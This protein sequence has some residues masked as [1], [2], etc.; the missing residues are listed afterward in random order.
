MPYEL[1][2]RT[3]LSVTG[4]IPKS[5]DGFARSQFYDVPAD[6]QPTWEF[7]SPQV[8]DMHSWFDCWRYTN[9]ILFIRRID[10]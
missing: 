3:I 4:G 6:A 8:A 5:C 10:G 7:Y 9:N 2:C 1:A